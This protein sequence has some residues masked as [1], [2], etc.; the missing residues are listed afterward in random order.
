VISPEYSGFWNSDY[1]QRFPLKLTDIWRYRI[2][3]LCVLSFHL[4]FKALSS[5]PTV[6]LYIRICSWTLF[7]IS[8]TP[9][10]I[11]IACTIMQ[12]SPTQVLVLSVWDVCIYIHVCEYDSFH[13]KC[14][15]PKSTKSKSRN[16][17]FL[18]ISRYRF[19]LRFW[20]NL[21]LYRGIWVSGFGGF[22]GC[23]IF[24]RSQ[25]HICQ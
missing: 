2:H 8:C 13:S 18:S 20:F 12:N 6:C 10:T 17:N 4:Q 16:S 9:T 15:T 19:R 22:R 5:P 11:W 25:L 7:R 23:S 14:N 21:A 24:S 3:T 1:R